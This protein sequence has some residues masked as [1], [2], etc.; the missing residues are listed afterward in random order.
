MD[1]KFHYF[2]QIDNIEA[3]IQGIELLS[4][5][6]DATIHTVFQSFAKENG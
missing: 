6:D 3:Q 2:F 1:N 5:Q 4:F